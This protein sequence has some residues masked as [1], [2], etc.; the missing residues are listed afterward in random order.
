[1]SD[2]AQP[3]RMFDILERPL[4]DLS[5]S[6]ASHPE[7]V[8]YLP[9]RPKRCTLCAAI[10]SLSRVVGTS[11]LSVRRIGTVQAVTKHEDLTF[12][13]RQPQQHANQLSNQR[14]AHG[15]V[16][17]RC[18]RTSRDSAHSVGY[19]RAHRC[20]QIKPT[21]RTGGNLRLRRE[22]PNQ[23]SP[24]LWG[25]RICRSERCLK[26]PAERRVVGGCDAREFGVDLPN[27]VD[28]AMSHI[29]NLLVE[30]RGVGRQAVPD[31]HRAAVMSRERVPHAE[32]RAREGRHSD[33]STHCV[34]LTH[35]I[36]R[37][38]KHLGQQRPPA[39]SMS[40]GL[41]AHLQ[42]LLETPTRVELRSFIRSS[43]CVFELPP[44]TEFVCPQRSESLP[45]EGLDVRLS[46]P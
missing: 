17:R 25:R 46:H 31:R 22:Y 12:S 29:S 37:I 16:R 1:M 2:G 40:P 27:P 38:G 7:L 6:L 44:Q 23:R 11:R 42:R 32:Q 13:L 26:R 3:S 35:P 43:E 28:P 45:N 30:P 39:V 4:F 33:G 5:N 21:L 36:K 14:F 24:V 10:A 15:P 8:A 9:K 19:S 41:F 34:R 18:D 20:E